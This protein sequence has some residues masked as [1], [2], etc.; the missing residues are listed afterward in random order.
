MTQTILDTIHPLN[1]RK[2]F[3]QADLYMVANSTIAILK[4]KAEY[5]T[6]DNFKEMCN[7]IGDMAKL[8]EVRKLVFDKRS[9]KIFHQPSMTWYYTEWKTE[10]SRY[11][12]N[13]HRKILPNDPLFRQSVKIGRE[14]INRE[15]PQA[16]YHHLDIQ[17]F[18]TLD[19]AIEQ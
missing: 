19:E 5:I 7:F 9:L 11:G 8:G 13:R 6:I 14:K 1:L 2:N 4:S 15:Y 18:E 16:Q 3:D 12:L 10:V 17:Y